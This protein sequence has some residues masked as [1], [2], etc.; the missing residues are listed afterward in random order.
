MG[1]L[2]GKSTSAPPPTHND[3]NTTK[4]KVK[5]SDHELILA[6]MKIC[7]DKIDAKLRKLD[8]Q[9]M[10]LESKIKAAV[11]SKK[12]EEAYFFLKQK[13]T[14][15]DAKVSTRKRLE[16]LQTQIDSIETMMEEAKFTELIGQGNRAI[17]ALSKDIDL[18]EIEIAKQLQAEGKLRRDEIDQLLGQDEDNEDLIQELNHIEAQM[19]KDNFEANPSQAINTNPTTQSSSS[20]GRLS[21]EDKQ[22]A[23]LN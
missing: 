23:L 2:F 21:T 1:G 5:V 13:K 11:H 22:A 4:P 19:I 20:K 6:K 16:L 8:A 12:K 14:I 15:K 10:G 18:Q 3:T 7:E 9:E 17:E